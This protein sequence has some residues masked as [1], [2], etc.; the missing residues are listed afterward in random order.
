[1]SKKSKAAA[2]ELRLQKK[3]ALKNAN[4]AKYAAWKQ[5]GENSKS[6][7][8]V[9]RKKNGKTAKGLHLTF[10]GNLACKKCFS[11]DEFETIKK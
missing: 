8:S 10:C 11:H 2:K 1:M 9:K 6:Y 7:R 3:R 4:K 5:A